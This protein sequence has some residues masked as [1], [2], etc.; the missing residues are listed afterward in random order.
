MGRRSYAGG[1]IF[2]IEEDEISHVDVMCYGA[3]TGSLAVIVHGGVPPYQFSID[4]ENW[5]SEEYFDNLS[6][7]DDAVKS[8]DEYGGIW[9]G[10]YTM[11]C[12]D[13]RGQV[14]MVKATIKSPIE[15]VFIMPELDNII[16]YNNVIHILFV[17]DPAQNYA[18]MPNPINF[19]PSLSTRAGNAGTNLEHTTLYGTYNVGNHQILYSTYN[20]CEQDAELSFYIS[21]APRRLPNAVQDYDGNWYDAVIVGN[22]VWLGSNLRTTHCADGTSVNGAT[23]GIDGLS[24]TWYDMMQ[25]ETQTNNNPSNVKGIS[26]YGWH[27][28]SNSE[29]QELIDYLKTI[30]Q[31]IAGDN[32]D[33]IAKS[34]SA[35]SYWD[36][37]TVENAVGNDLSLNNLS[38]LEI[39]PGSQKFP[40]RVIIWTCTNSS[41][42]SYAKTFTID[43]DRAY[44]PPNS[45]SKNSTAYVRLVCD[46]DALTFIKWYWNTYGSFDH[47]LS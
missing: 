17:A 2:N 27:I 11:Y 20:D 30:P 39:Y 15:L 40:F 28:P 33:N 22:K 47:Q 19:E 45:Y 5:Q 23:G 44:V 10:K 43:N 32:N 26:I 13:A 3:S 37:S 34:I 16:T 46:M 31:Y 36:T 18:T 21:V 4:G 35:T 8:T 25:N 38:L 1:G 24:Y 41:P 42:S 7:P 9:I 12:K 14:R 29:F 6:V